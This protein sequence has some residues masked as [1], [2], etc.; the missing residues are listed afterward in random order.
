[1]KLKLVKYSIFIKPFLMALL[2]A[3]NSFANAAPSTGLKVLVEDLYERY[4]WEAAPENHDKI[5]YGITLHNE[6]LVTLQEYFSN[7]LAS[8]IWKDTEASIKSGDLGEIDFVIIYDSQDPYVQKL[9]VTSLDEMRVE[10]CFQN[11]GS[12]DHCLIYKGEKKGS[13]YRIRDII[14]LRHGGS[15]RQM[16][17]LPK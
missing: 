11:Y 9:K 16:L 7:D 17:S 3:I 12:V 4:E 10:V 15:L 13:S 8:A 2:L 6:K 14:Y 5:V 1:M